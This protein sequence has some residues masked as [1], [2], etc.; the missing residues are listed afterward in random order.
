MDEIAAAGL[1]YMG[2]HFLPQRMQWLQDRCTW[3]MNQDGQEVRSRTKY[4][5]GT[6][7]RLFQDVAVRDT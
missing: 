5:L 1:M 2:L 7:H 6:Y 4:I 3:S